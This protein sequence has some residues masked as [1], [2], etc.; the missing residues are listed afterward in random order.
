VHYGAFRSVLQLQAISLFQVYG[1][2]DPETFHLDK[3]QQACHSWGM[4]KVDQ[5]N[6]LK[7]KKNL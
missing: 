2:G 1:Q 6:H 7:L 4:K 3:E 5:F